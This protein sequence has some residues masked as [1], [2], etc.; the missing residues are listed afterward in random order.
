MDPVLET[1][2][3]PLSYTP[4]LINRI[5]VDRKIFFNHALYI[6][7]GAP[8]IEPGSLGL[9]ANMFVRYTIRP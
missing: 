4:I 1:G 2:A 7:A 8:G 5:F 3:L 6:M 9:E